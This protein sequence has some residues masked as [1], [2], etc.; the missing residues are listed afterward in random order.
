MCPEI[1]GIAKGKEEAMDMVTEIIQAAFY[2]KTGGF[3]HQRILEK[4]V[5]L[6]YIFCG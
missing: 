5:N 3:E 4:Q 6:C 1:I 2:S